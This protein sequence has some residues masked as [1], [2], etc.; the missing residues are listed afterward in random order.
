MKAAQHRI[1]Y[2][3]LL[4]YLLILVTWQ[5]LFWAQLI[6]DYL[7]PSPVQVA[8]RLWE[9][10]ADNYLWP[11][12]KA[13]FERMGIGFGISATL[14]LLI[15]LFMGMSRV[16]NSCLRSLF[17]GL[18]TLPTAAWVPVSLLFFG[19]S[20]HGIYF[21][22]IMSSAP[23]IAIAISD[24]IQHIPPIYL[25]AARTLG[26]PGYA[27]PTRVILPA[28]LPSIV[29]GIKLGWTLAWHGDVSAELIKSSIGLGYL[30]QMG[31]ELNDAAQVIGVMVLTILF[32]LLLDRFVFGLVQ[33]RILVRWGLAEKT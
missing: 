27:M 5:A 24:G 6:P 8:R 21:V 3:V 29:T 31:R 16:V 13:T 10:G 4:F 28:S 25:R 19:L 17:L 30:L 14:G 7:F 11:S 26:T 18:Q 15:G 9:L 32:G 23:A 22:I 33:K 12:V 2:Y 1:K 20:D